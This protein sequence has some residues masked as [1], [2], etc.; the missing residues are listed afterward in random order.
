MKII[1]ILCGVILL[2][3]GLWVYHET[4]MPNQY[5][6]FTGAP[7]ASVADLIKNPK[8]FMKKTVALAGVVQEQCE[9]AGCYFY[10]PDGSNSLRID[11]QDIL[12]AAL[13]RN[14]HQ[15]RVEGQI[16]KYGDGY[17]LAASAIEFK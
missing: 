11:L 3:G 6:T 1:F 4:R 2:A 16:V 10:F 5:G 8:S 14:G 13:Q 12:T 17:Q 7:P 9:A 15:A